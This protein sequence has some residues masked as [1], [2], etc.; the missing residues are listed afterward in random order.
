MGA[1]A[2]ITVIQFAV[3]E[4]KDIFMPDVEIDAD[5]PFA[6]AELIDADSCVIKLLHPWKDP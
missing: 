6:L 2:F 5:C 4:G 3:Q 1:V